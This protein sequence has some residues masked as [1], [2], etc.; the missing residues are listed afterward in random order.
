MAGF[1]NKIRA[2]GCFLRPYIRL[3]A[4]VNFS[5]TLNRADM[6]AIKAVATFKKFGFYVATF[7]TGMTPL[8]T[9]ALQV[10]FKNFAFTDHAL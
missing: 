10:T 3:L 9:I 1:C 4:V 8:D 5:A 7:A 6:L 2:K